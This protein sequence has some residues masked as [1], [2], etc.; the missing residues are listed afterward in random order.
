MPVCV[1]SC[2]TK[3]LNIG[4]VQWCCWGHM[5]LCVLANVSFGPRHSKSPCVPCLLS[6][7]EMGFVFGHI[8]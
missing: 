4:R 3:G 8:M 6:R 1:V 7:L 2:D 5:H